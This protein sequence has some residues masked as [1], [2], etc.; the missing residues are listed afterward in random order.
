MKEKL[1]SKDNRSACAYAERIISESRETDEWY[2]RFDEFASLLN[3]PKSLVRN[4][5][6]SILAANARW[7]GENRFARILPEY[8]S[9][10]TDEKPITARQCVKALAEIGQAQPKLIPEIT[11]ALRSADLS[12][13]RDSMRP[14]I[15]RDI[16]ETME[17]LTAFCSGR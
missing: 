5:A 15:E 1:T 16:S 10:I 2:A 7:D 8:L 11:A 3:H 17:K 12:Q 9:H 14:L 13:Y 4:R 6:L